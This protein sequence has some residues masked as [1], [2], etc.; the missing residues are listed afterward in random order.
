MDRLVCADG[1]NPDPTST[2]GKDPKLAKQLE[3]E[4]WDYPRHL[5]GRA[6]SVVVH[7]DAA[8]TE[9][10]RRMLVDWLTDMHLVPAGPSAQ[11]D[12]YIGYYQ[13]Y[14]GSHAE[15]DRDVA[16]HEEIRNAARVLAMKIRS[17]R[18]QSYLPEV[19]LPEPR[20]K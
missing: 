13:S 20:P 5:A 12:R 19:T 2:Q 3:L 16:L 11:L 4:G 15:F 9:N 8:G 10:L 14:A 18:S 17:I 7:G 6:F 1:G